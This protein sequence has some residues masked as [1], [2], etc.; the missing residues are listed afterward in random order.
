M[1]EKSKEE[2]IVDYVMSVAALDYAMK[3]YKEQKAEL[4]KSVFCSLKG[5]IAS[6]SAAI[7]VT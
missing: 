6:S 7:D 2:R 4:R 1:S 3:P 5:F